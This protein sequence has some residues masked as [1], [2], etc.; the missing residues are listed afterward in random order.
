[1]MQA[2]LIVGNGS[3]QA[4][5]IQAD[6]AGPVCMAFAELIHAADRQIVIDAVTALRRLH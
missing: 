6:D 4:P 1:M 2:G 5:M 3:G